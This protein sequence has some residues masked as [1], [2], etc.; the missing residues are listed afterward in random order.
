MPDLAPMGLLT[1]RRLTLVLAACASAAVAQVPPAATVRHA[2]LASGASASAPAT[3]ATSP[4]LT[5]PDVDAWL[6][7]ILPYALET[8][9]V[10]GGV[11][12]VVQD[13]KIVTERG[14]GYADVATR[15]P[16]DPKATLFRPGST[17]K[18]FT[19]TA[20]M[21]QV[22]VG[23]IDLNKDVNTYL[24]FKIPPYE[25]KPITMR[26]IMT[27]TAGFEEALEGLMAASSTAAP[28]TLDAVLKRWIPKR[29]FAP[30][31]TPAYSNYATM[32]AGY[33]VQRV[34]GEPYDQYI[35][36]HVFQPIGMSHS[37]MV[38]P[39]PAPLAAM[40]SN[41]YAR[42]SQPAKPYEVITFRPAGSATVSADD[43][44]R[45]MIAHLDPEHNALLKP[46]TMRMMHDSALTILPQVNRMELGFYEANL[47]GHRI[48]AHG[49]DT[50]W[51]H[52]YLWLLPDDRT[53][54]FFSMNSAGAGTASLT[55]REALIARFMD[56]YF[57]AARTKTLAFTPRPADA[58]MLAGTY[59][60][61][62]RSESGLRR[63]LNF[64]SQTT[65]TADAKGGLH[66]PRRL[67]R[68]LR[69][70]AARL[71]GN[72][73]VRLEGSGR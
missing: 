52:S 3:H 11:V 12:A 2:K 44:A 46:Q 10:A 38:E 65:V 6:D 20:V 28:P 37:T 40:M 50:Q 47:N 21:Q 43:M 66:I 4:T 70:R 35:A 24:D 63:A 60:E 16:V 27:H 68:G 17:S 34:S 18:L 23:K 26:Q 13:G 36:R 15:K 39:L 33:I 45:F 22:E 59:Q 72:R 5:K 30:G 32:L 73:T 8:G 25:G 54:I 51:F 42:A 58:A 62:R 49:G 55:I 29:V 56:R 53:G 41:G 1:M 19:W 57:P 14:Y 9:D 64:F 31:T 67:F 48:I 7:G 71:G 69:R 61:S